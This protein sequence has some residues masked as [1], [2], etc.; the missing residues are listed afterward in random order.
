VG[1]PLNAEQD[2]EDSKFPKPARHDGADVEDPVVQEAGRKMCGI[3]RGQVVSNAG[4]SGEHEEDVG[5]DTQQLCPRG[6][7]KPR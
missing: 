7:G 3:Y 5:N 6:S 1:F 4:V 2:V